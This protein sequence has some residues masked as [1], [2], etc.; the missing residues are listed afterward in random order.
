MNKNSK[1]KSLTSEQN[2]MPS[3]S[4]K[5]FPES[6]TVTQI[7]HFKD[8]VK[9]TF[10]GI[11]PQTIKQGQYTKMSTIDGRILVVNDENVLMI[12][13]FSETDND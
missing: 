13:V 2:L 5:Y 6:E 4:T 3:L 10:S 7:I 12:E 11:L 9:R 8:N 1:K